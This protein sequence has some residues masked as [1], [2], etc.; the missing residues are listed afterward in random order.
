V[1]YL[2][3]YFIESTEQWQI[4]MKIRVCINYKTIFFSHLIVRFFF[5]IENVTNYKISLNQYLY[6]DRKEEKK[7]F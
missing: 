3:T 5:N 2:S 6:I 7:T 1:L 4:Q